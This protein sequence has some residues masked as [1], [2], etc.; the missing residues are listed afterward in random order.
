MTLYHVQI[1]KREYKV[2][3]K[4]SECIVD[5]EAVQLDLERLNEA[6]L[7][8]LRLGNQSVELVMQALS[9]RSCELITRGRRWLAEIE[10]AH[11]RSRKRDHD[12]PPGNVVAPMPGMIVEINVSPGEHVSAGQVLAVQE[13]M[14]MQM[15]LRA[16]ADGVVKHVA[17]AMGDQVEKGAVIIELDVFE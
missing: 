16:P 9:E 4:G 2:Q 7:H 10:P 6:G 12:I 15:H 13:A 3:L 17:I 5:G 14:K 11:R 8:Q 1:G